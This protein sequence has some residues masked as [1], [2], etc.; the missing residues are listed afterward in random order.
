M[1]LNSNIDD[2]IMLGSLP[3]SLGE[4]P[5][6]PSIISSLVKR[7]GYNFKFIDINLELFKLCDQ[8]TNLYQT[9]TQIL[10]SFKDI[11]EDKIISTWNNQV[12]EQLKTCKYLI[13]NVFSHFS[14][15]TAY[16]FIKQI[17]YRY[18]TIT[19]FLGG[20]GSQK[21]I[22]NSNDIEIHKWLNQEFTH[23][24][25]LIF[26]KLL[27]ENNLIDYWQSDAT[28]SEI[29]NKL[30]ARLNLN[31][32]ISSVDFSIYD[33]NSYQ[34][35]NKKKTIPMLGSYGC[36]RQ[37]SFCDVMAHFPK[38]NFVEADSLTK[39]I[40]EAYNETSISNIVF[41]DSLVNGSMSNFLSL[42]K[43]LKQSKENGWLPPDFS[44]SGTYICRQK[45]TLLDEIHTLLPA[46]G[47]DNL[48]IGVESGSDRIRFE[49]E[50][51]FTNKDLFYEL[52]AFKK[53]NIKASLLFFPSWPTETLEDFAET[54]DLF[55]T[56]APFAHSGTIETISLGTVGFSLIDETPIDRN[57]EKIGL[58]NG[59][60]P[61]LWKCL[62]NPEL[63]FWETIR[64]RLKMAQCCESLGIRLSVENT[65]RN[66][67]DFY[68]E[69][70]YDLIKSYAGLMPNE[71]LTD[72]IKCN[73]NTE[74]KLSMTIVNSNTKPVFVQLDQD[75]ANLGMYECPPGLTNIYWHI[76]TDITQSSNFNLKIRFDDS[77]KVEWAQYENGDYYSKTGIYLDNI[78]LD[79]KNITFWGWN[80][81]VTQQL[82]SMIDLPIDYDSHINQRAITQDTNLTWSINAETSFHKHLLEVTSPEEYAQRKIIDKRLYKKLNSMTQSP[83]SDL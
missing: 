67:L 76:K 12:L 11:N 1:T 32:K 53:N 17:R 77:Y 56:L 55:R 59:P 20:I 51:K 65:F 73:F 50:K 34:W 46:S 69:Q 82:L 13:V 36:V 81:L 19:I 5:A 68:L 25:N 22:S 14:Q 4:L 72:I 2:V 23:I 79:N 31:T 43:N 16:R 29:E 49:M 38:Y 54:L 57:K 48:V 62:T 30:P 40:V 75:L 27:L 6:A 47:V 28:A 10:Q 3:M 8:D 66:Y 78:Y 37:C 58:V 7:K 83:E 39:S 63:T 26:G 64:R 70:H 80:Q 61:F 45:S 33:L 52:S 18:P 35:D 71:V 60:A 44:W 9:K 21:L 24:S 41:M 42:L 74:S 15:A